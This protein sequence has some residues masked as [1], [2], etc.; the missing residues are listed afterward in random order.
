MHDTLSS[1][2]LHHSTKDNRLQSYEPN[3]NQPRWTWS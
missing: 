1:N 2:A 3:M